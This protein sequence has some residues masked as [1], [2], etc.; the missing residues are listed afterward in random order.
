MKNK[1]ET[2]VVE[3]I[4]FPK[5]DVLAASGDNPVETAEIE[6]AYVSISSFWSK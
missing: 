1:Y 5:Q 6:N 4:N 3:V 2:P